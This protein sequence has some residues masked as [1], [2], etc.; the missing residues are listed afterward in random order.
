MFHLVNWTPSLISKSWSFWTLK[1]PYNI[2]WAL[3]RSPLFL[4]SLSV[5]KPIGFTQSSYIFQFPKSRYL[6]SGS[7]L[8]FSQHFNICHFPWILS[9]DCIFKVWPHIGFEQFWK[10]YFIFA[11]YIFA[12]FSRTWFAFF[13]TLEHCRWDLL[14]LHII[15]H[16]H[17]Q[18]V[19]YKYL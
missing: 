13:D 9:L 17:I 16:I 2:L 3:I 15:T 14:L 5:I 8:D 7:S 12:Q 18:V 19:K 10:G 6:F 4:L 11:N 1:I